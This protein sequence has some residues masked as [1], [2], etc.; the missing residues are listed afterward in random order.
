[1]SVP[2]N[3]GMDIVIA[4]TAALA[5]VY[6]FHFYFETKCVIGPTST[7]LLCGELAP[8][9]FVLM[10]GVLA[11]ISGNVVYRWYKNRIK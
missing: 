1:M 2:K 11:F 3:S 10:V 7:L 9:G 6:E 4:V 8:I 5:L